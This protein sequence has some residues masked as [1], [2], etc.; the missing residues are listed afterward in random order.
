[1]LYKGIK[2]TGENLQSPSSGVGDGMR[3]DQKGRN[4]NGRKV[5]GWSNSTDE[6]AEMLWREVEKSC[7]LTAY[8]SESYQ[9]GNIIYTQR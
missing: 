6:A 4:A 8:H 3:N 9:K 2:A 7:I 5:V 1:M